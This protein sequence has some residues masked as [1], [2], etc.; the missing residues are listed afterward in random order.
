MIDNMNE[1][2]KYAG[3]F[4]CFSPTKECDKKR[5]GILDYLKISAGNQ[6][7]IYPCAFYETAEEKKDNLILLTSSVLKSGA[8]CVYLTR[9]V[10]EEEI[11]GEISS[12]IPA[13]AGN[14]TLSQFRV[15]DMGAFCSS[16]DRLGVG[17]VAA[18][19]KK[20][21]EKT[22]LSCVIIDADR[23]LG[24][25]EPFEQLPEL[26][27]IMKA[28]FNDAG[29]SKALFLYDISK[30]SLKALREII[31]IHPLVIWKGEVLD[32]CFF[33]PPGSELKSNHETIITKGWLSILKEK[34]ASRN[35]LAGNEVC[36]RT[37]FENAGTAICIID[38]AGV[39]RLMNH[40]WEDILGYSKAQ[41]EG[42]TS[43][44]DLVYIDDKKN[45]KN[46]IG[47]AGQ[48]AENSSKNFEAR[49][50]NSEG[51]TLYFAFTLD[52]IACCNNLIISAVDITDLK[53]ENGLLVSYHEHLEELV[54]KRTRKLRREMEKTKSLASEISQLY[55]Q[56]TELR[57]EL[58]SASH[59]NQKFTRFLVHELKTPLT[60]MMGSADILFEKAKGTE[61]ERLAANIHRGAHSLSNRV[62]DLLDL[63]R[64]DM[65]LLHL[66][67]GWVDLP[68]LLKEVVCDMT[69]EFERRKQRVCLDI[70]YF[71]P[72]VW[73]DADRLRQIVI[74]LLGN[75]S[76]FTPGDGRIFIKTMRVENSLITTIRDTGCGIA[77][78]R[79]ATI[80][81]DYSAQPRPDVPAANMGIGLH[82][83]KLLTELH[84]GELW[85][86]SIEGE[87][88]EF[89]FSLPIERD[90]D[91]R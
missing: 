30:F 84:G 77:K 57:K 8:T 83:C 52:M 1:Q 61:F 3:N 10:S 49:L 7:G 22:P 48:D 37:I 51:Q 21:I 50:I 18:Y 81:T 80:F 71:T 86:S 20:E 29:F 35:K 69:Y 19:L 88:S 26:K 2:K 76:K 62:N 14:L 44:L 9:G 12:K 75:A 31:S 34:Q 43:F 32:N 59:E 41:L 55:Q 38:R 42:K 73:A 65:G 91:R 58:E 39:I 25:K 67:C 36:Y 40:Q 5:K 4:R 17:A 11:T 68:G 78:E 70:D 54:G 47:S 53:N 85:V 16:E 24:N 13:A 28:D 15:V 89:S 45:V 74:N 64:G 63:A 82:L 27:A 60:P 66:S 72:L 90:E 56:E 46:Y 23:I 33:I 87:G 6:A 79:Q